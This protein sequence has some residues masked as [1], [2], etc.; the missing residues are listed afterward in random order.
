[1]KT[2]VPSTSRIGRSLSSEISFGKSFRFTMYSNE[3]TFSVP[4]GVMKFWRAIA[5][6]TSCD[7]S[8]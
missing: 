8:P 2:G 1:M 4:T 5:P 6:T 7:E 3:P